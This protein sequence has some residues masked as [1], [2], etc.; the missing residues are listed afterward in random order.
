[1]GK[2]R[3][4]RKAFW[5]GKLLCINKIKNGIFTFLD[6]KNKVYVDLTSDVF[7]FDYL[8]ILV[9]DIKWFEVYCKRGND[10]L[11]LL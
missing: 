7:F 5:K 9:F 10:F 11:S 2:Q 6:L 1:M 8:D 3:G 4:G